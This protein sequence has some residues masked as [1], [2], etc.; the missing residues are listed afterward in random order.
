MVQVE[1]LP[2]SPSGGEPVAQV[3]QQ[4]H[5]HSDQ[6][7][8]DKEKHGVDRHGGG[9]ERGANKG[10]DQSL[11]GEAGGQPLSAHEGERAKTEEV[12]QA[13]QQDQQGRM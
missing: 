6:V 5:A 1:G 2:I 9:G 3:N 13:D 12:E 11:D 7:D 10:D 8:D 4:P